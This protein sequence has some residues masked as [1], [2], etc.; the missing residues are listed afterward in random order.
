MGNRVSVLSTRLI[1]RLHQAVGEFDIL[2]PRPFEPVGRQSLLLALVFIGGISISILFSFQPGNLS[3]PYFWGEYGVL[4]LLVLLIFF[5]NMRP[6]HRLMA[7]RKKAELDP[8]QHQIYQ[9][10][11]ML[12]DRLAQEQPAGEL[13]SVI[14]SLAVFEAHL[15]NAP[16]WPYNTAMLRALVFSVLIPLLSVLARV[17][18]ELIR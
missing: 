6:T 13:P 4:V 15:L 7:A 12:Q 10:S 16:T 14:Q 5:L 2:D 11:R 9:Y 18:V 8:L 17:L 1:T 3:S